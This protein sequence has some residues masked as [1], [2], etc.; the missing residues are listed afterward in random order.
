MECNA[1]RLDGELTNLERRF[2]DDFLNLKREVEGLRA[3][4]E[5]LSE[6]VEALEERAM[7]A[8]RA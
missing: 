1:D 8:H 4:V 6:R 7:S 3:L 5:K 2:D